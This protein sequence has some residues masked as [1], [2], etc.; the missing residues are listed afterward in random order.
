V[1]VEG[2]P[3]WHINFVGENA[4]SAL[5]TESFNRVIRE[6]YSRNSANQLTLRASVNSGYIRSRHS[7]GM[8]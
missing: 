8:G 3:V 7:W 4:S 5:L 1:T 6:L 2:D